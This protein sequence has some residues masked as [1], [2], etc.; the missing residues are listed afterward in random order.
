MTHT[1]VSQAGQQRTNQHQH[2]LLKSLD[3][4]TLISTLITNKTLKYFHL[5]A[6]TLNNDAQAK[7]R[8]KLC[9]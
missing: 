7:N 2:K 5:I 4:D 3:V 1:D 6:N 8:Y 9:I